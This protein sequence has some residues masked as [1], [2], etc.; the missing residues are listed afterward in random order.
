MKVSEQ[1]TDTELTPILQAVGISKHY[2]LRR[3][4]M[5]RLKG[6]PARVVR[7]VDN[8]NLSIYPGEVI[9][10]I[11]ESGCGKTTLGKVLCRLVD[12]TSGQLFLNGDD[13]LAIHGEKLRLLRPQF[14]MLF[15]NPYS[16]LNPKLN[17]FRTLE[18]T[19]LVNF[20][21]TAEE[22]KTKVR[23][24][25]K[26]VGL[27][28]KELSF[29]TEMSGGERRRVGLAKLLLLR[30]RLIIADEP[31]AGLDASIKARVVD[32][33][34]NART[35]EMAYLFISHDLHVIH[36]VSD[37]IL[38]MYLGMIVEELPVSTFDEHTHHPYTETLL[39]AARQVSLKK[40]AQDDLGFEDLPSHSELE[41]EG[42]PYV[43][44]CPLAG[45][46]VDKERCLHER[47]PLH[48]VAEQHRIACHVF[49]EKEGDLS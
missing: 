18:E 36:Y 42:C 30:P 2:A 6:E 48:L 43:A 40:D 29:P 3:S 37:R 21:M 19:L 23:E 33:M 15:Q 46:K 25:L 32:L 34:L 44:R 49:E 5:K 20:E 1:Q 38:V 8:V 26:Q 35:E 10:V 45:L 22:R 31:V 47:P 11:G 4:L 14:Q 16:T 24:I 9:G 12:S 13:L 7:A 17:V 28:S 41:S 39:S 27:E